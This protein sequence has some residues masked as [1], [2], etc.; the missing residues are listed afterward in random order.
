MGVFFFC[1][2]CPVSYLSPHEHLSLFSLHLY[3]NPHSHVPPQAE[4]GTVRCACRR[5]ASPSRPTV[6]ICSVVRHEPQHTQTHRP[7]MTPYTSS[8]VD[9]FSSVIH[10][11]ARSVGYE[12]EFIHFSV[13][14]SFSHLIRH[15]LI[16]QSDFS[17]GGASVCMSQALSGPSF[18][19][20]NN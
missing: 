1:F 15:V 4:T 10:A 16:V 17:L 3:R 6:V 5:P 9:K 2:L 8:R 20:L 7:T 18:L 11:F 13:T 12:T 14:L 19:A